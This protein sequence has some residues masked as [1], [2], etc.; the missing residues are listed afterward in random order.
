MP[1]NSRPTDLDATRRTIVTRELIATASAYLTG[2]IALSLPFETL[3]PFKAQLLKFFSLEDWSEDD[4]QNLSDQVTPHIAQGW[5]EHDLGS[6][7][8]LSYGIRD[9]RFELWVGGA[10]TPAPSIFDRVFEGPVVP[11]A[12]PHPRKVKFTTGGEAAPGIWYRRSDPGQPSDRRVERLFDEPDVTDVMV[13]GDFVT[14]GIAARSSWEKR[15]EPLLALTTELF[16]H[17]EAAHHQP[18]RTREQLMQ[19]AGQIAN[20]ARPEVLHLLDPNDESDREVLEK[21]LEAPDPRAR[22]VAV[23]VLLESND[24]D[25][26]RRAVGAGMADS[27]R[28][29]RR[30][31]VDA[32]AD[33]GDERFRRLFEE[34][35][36]EDDP[37]IRWKAIRSLGELGLSNSRSLVEKMVDDPDFQVRFEV[38]RVLRAAPAG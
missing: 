11:E 14:I 6:G 21:A 7:V 31:A 17:P 25:T 20:P 16:A 29:V 37:W 33:A 9:N 28:A 35:L 3:V 1:V 18:G 34:V 22:R 4:A 26:R 30:T 23:A 2:D 15:L 8:T 32:A 24:A 19:E 10:G 36:T 12:T 13:A 38:A 5:W 27:S